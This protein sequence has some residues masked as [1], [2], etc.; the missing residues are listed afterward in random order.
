MATWDEKGSEDAK[1]LHALPH[2][3]AEGELKREEHDAYKECDE[4]ASLFILGADQQN[5]TLPTT[6]GMQTR[7]GPIRCKCY[8][9]QFESLQRYGQCQL[10]A[11]LERFPPE[12]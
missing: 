7:S 9:A 3:R 1:G 6:P 11:H 8:R 4:N 5:P 12:C 10:T 2:E